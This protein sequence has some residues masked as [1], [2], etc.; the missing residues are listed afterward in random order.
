MWIFCERKKFE[1]HG[2]GSK[3]SKVDRYA[4]LLAI[5]EIFGKGGMF[6]TTNI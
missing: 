3:N 1:Q 4:T 2:Y 6:K 5:K